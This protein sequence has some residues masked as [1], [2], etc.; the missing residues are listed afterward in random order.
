[1]GSGSDCIAARGSNGDLRE[2]ERERE[3]WP[4]EGT[5]RCRKWAFVSTLSR[6]VVKVIRCRRSDKHNC[7]ATSSSSSA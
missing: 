5:Q 2:K 1:M 3:R 4:V 6:T 7:Y